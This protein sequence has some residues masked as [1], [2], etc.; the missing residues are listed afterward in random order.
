LLRAFGWRDLIDLGDITNARA[1]EAI[2]PLWIRLWGVLETGDF[3][4]K[5]ASL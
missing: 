5:V 2:L 3:N 1:T 4:L